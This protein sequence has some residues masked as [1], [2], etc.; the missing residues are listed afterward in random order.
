V[1]DGS[2]ARISPTAYYTGH[3]WCRNGLSDP[4]LDTREGAALFALMRPAMRVGRA[5][6]GG[7]A[8]EEMLLQRHRI[9]DHLLSQAIESGRVGQVLE[10][11]AGMSGRGVRFARRYGP[12]GLVYVEGD[13]AG[14][15]AL[16]RSRL[17]SAG[18]QGEGH[19]IVAL[20]VL[21]GGG[22]L[23]LEQA[24]A[25]LLDPRKGIAV[26]TEGLL[27][28]FDTPTAEGLWRRLSGFVAPFAGDVYLSDLHVGGAYTSRPARVFRRMLQVFVR[29]RTHTHFARIADVAPA[30]AGHGFARATVH[31]PRDWSAE[32]SLP[33]A[34]GLETVQVL[35]ASTRAS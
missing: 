9:I 12:R 35:E 7:V 11:A 26:V 31:R 2:T 8:L 27:S 21:A 19:H 33:G 1:A 28:Y 16:K 20:D 15:A 3:V 24:T 22:P 14:M 30:L 23:A 34:G 13:L 6:T 29:G 10:I 25:R 18:L 4:A 17:A 32:L 5:L